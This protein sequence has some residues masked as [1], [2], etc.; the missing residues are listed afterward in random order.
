MMKK[1]NLHLGSCKQAFRPQVWEY[2][3]CMWW[4]HSLDHPCWLGHSHC[5]SFTEISRTQQALPSCCPFPYQWGKGSY[6]SLLPFI[7]N[8]PL[9]RKLI[10]PPFSHIWLRKLN[11]L[12]PILGTRLIYFMPLEKADD[13]SGPFK[14]RSLSPPEHCW[15]WGFSLIILNILFH[16]GFIRGIIDTYSCICLRGTVCWVDMF[17]NC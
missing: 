2:R 12:R 1:M 4:G 5:W 17:I 8:S 9:L 11:L 15:K 6:H 3:D 10:Y 7:T 13:N 16:L 14:T